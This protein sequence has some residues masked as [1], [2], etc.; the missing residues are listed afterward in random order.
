[1]QTQLA[2]P[3][4]VSHLDPPELVGEGRV[5]GKGVVLVDRLVA[6]L[7][8]QNLELGA[9]Q[10]VQQAGDVLICEVQLAL[11]VRVG[12]AVRTIEEQEDGRL[13]GG[14]DELDVPRLELAHQ[15]ARA[16]GVDP[17]QLAVLRLGLVEL[18]EHLHAFHLQ[19]TQHDR[20]RRKPL[21]SSRVPGICTR[22]NTQS[23]YMLLVMR[24]PVCPCA[25]FLLVR[26][27]VSLAAE[28]FA[29]A[30]GVG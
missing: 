14:E 10:G 18:L 22:L 29:Q 1:M 30:N 3:P 28:P 21:L 13:V 27:L 9:R 5:E 20:V 25:P 17:G 4:A 12:E 2:L 19:A 26:N 8:V 15:V 23:Q 7:L 16:Q 11:N 24:P 6:G